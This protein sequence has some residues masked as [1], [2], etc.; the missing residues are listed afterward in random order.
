MKK[1]FDKIPTLISNKK[2]F[3]SLKSISKIGLQPTRLVK[4]VLSFS[5]AV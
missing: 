3:M 5:K 2:T 4:L 1:L